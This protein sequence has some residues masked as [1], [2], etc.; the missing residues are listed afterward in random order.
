MGIPQHIIGYI[1]FQS[2]M[3]MSLHNSNSLILL[4]FLSRFN[5]NLTHRVMYN[6]N[7]LPH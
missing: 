7:E 5:R 4:T 2:E 6:Y 1:R 3:L